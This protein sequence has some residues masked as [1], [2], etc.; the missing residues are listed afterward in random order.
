MME[1]VTLNNGVEMP[2]IGTGTNTFGKVD[3]DYFGEVT[4]DTTELQSAI[5]AGYRAIDTAV[6]YRNESTVG[7]AIKESGL[8][9]EDFFITSKIPGD[10]DHAGSAEKVEATLNASLEAL[11]TDYIDLYL[12][13][14]PWDNENEMLQTW[15][16]LENAYNEG[17]I[18][19]I[20][21]SNFDQDQLDIIIDNARIQPMVNQIK[22]NVEVWND[23]IIEYSAENDVVVTAWAPMKGT[24]E[25]SRAIL[26]EI[27]AQYGKTWGQVLLRYQIE[28]GVVVIPK[29]HNAD[30]QADNLNVFDFNLSDAD[31]EKI[32]SL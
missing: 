7:K 17:K 31:K 18:K 11:Q 30:H 10:L 14:H 32:A 15:Y 24:D 2:I 9:R 20:G 22:S 21:V 3:G 1:F 5:A 25:A 28:R 4:D 29:S 13:H 27:G 6:A 8:P 26:D 23:D 16:A 12:I 19:A